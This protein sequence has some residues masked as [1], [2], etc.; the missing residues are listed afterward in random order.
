MDDCRYVQEFGPDQAYCKGIE[1]ILNSLDVDI[2][3]LAAEPGEE[4]QA[5][6]KGLCSN[7][8]RRHDCTFSKPV[9]GVYHCD[10]YC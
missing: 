8:D 7:C 1:R 4:V 6:F 10:E 9:G 5:R 3:L 2:A